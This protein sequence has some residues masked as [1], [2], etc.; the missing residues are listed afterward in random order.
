MS[1]SKKIKILWKE[2]V[3][4]ISG[5]EQDFTKGSISKAIFL[6]SIPMVLEMVMESVFAV[7]DI[8]FV[9]KLGAEAVSVVGITES[10]ITIIYALGI[11]FSTGTTALISRRIGE[12]KNDEA[13]IIA[14]QSII[15]GILVSI[16]ITIVGLFFSKD[17]LILMGASEEAI[18]IGSDYTL[19]MFSSNIVIMLLFIIN[20]VFRSAGDANISMKVLWLA[21]GINIILDPCLI[22]GWGFFPELGV[23]GAAIATV[24][25]RGVAVVF[26]IYLLFFGSK[27][28]KITAKHLRIDFAIIMKLLKVSIG[29]IA[30]YIIST[31]SW[32]FL[33]R[34]IASFGSIVIAGY[35]I[36][37][38][39]IMF[40][41]L[42]SWG[43]SNASATLTG[44]NLGAK[45]P[46]RAEKSV[47]LTAIINLIFL[48]IIATFLIIFSV[49]WL[50]LFIN[51]PE[52]I[53]NGAV[54]LRY[55]S[56]AL[57]AYS[58]GM[59]II[60]AFN[61]AG[62]TEI[63]TLLNFFCFW[64]FEI[65]LAYFLSNYT[66]LKEKGVYIAIISADILLTIIGVYLFKR[67]KWKTSKI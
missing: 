16:V 28:I 12:K 40:A 34:I 29:G 38:R 46:E 19:I 49:N 37:I 58:V 67:G 66:E 5:N 6:L 1:I 48:S 41:I 23:K 18:K 59:I 9:S 14:V 17:L 54:A 45:K 44:Q 33:I 39:I 21:N 20:A 57:F 56:F 7:V 42:P 63:P 50:K 2:L 26:Q 36:G 60:Q 43:M 27:R 24:I 30:Q 32:I 4:A 65:P 64:L 8:F 55:I 47:W 11:G 3:L 25:G 51:D 52:V 13:A 62:K 53:K 15:V 22:F 61:G 10:L 35:T 31:S